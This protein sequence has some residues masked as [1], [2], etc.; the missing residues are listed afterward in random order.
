MT[1]IWTLSSSTMEGRPKGM[2]SFGIWK[3]MGSRF[4]KTFPC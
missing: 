2:R 3:W 1:M 4:V